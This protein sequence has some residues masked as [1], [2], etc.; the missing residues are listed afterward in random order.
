MSKQQGVETVSRGFD[1]PKERNHANGVQFNTTKFRGI[2]SRINNK[3][4]LQ[5]GFCQSDMMKWVKI[6]G[7]ICWS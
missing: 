7:Y 3:N 6:Y 5:K 2:F 4:L 1:H